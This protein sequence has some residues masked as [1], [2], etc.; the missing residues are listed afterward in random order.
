MFENTN[1]TEWEFSTSTFQ[2]TLTNFVF[3]I[4]NIYIYIYKIYINLDL[5]KFKFLLSNFLVSL[6]LLPP[7]FCPTSI[8][9]KNCLMN[10]LMSLAFILV[11]W[12]SQFY[13]IK[14][15]NSKNDR[16]DKLTY[17]RETWFD[18]YEIENVIWECQIPVDIYL[19]KVNNRNTRLKCEIWS[20]LTIKIPERRQ[21]RR[22]GVFIA[23][24]KHISRLF[25]VFLLLTLN[26]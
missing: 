13:V 18:N 9:W 20:K 1:G 14:R 8:L 12:S 3:C 25:L 16:C 19:L 15:K 22:S 2:K 6:L 24:F 11:L 26:I 4:F 10:L 23:N 17:F 7:F 5:L 21:C